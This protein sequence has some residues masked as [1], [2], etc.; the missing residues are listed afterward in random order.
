M[1]LRRLLPI[2]LSF[3]L[4]AASTIE[5][6][7]ESVGSS[8]VTE[9]ELLSRALVLTEA[10]NRPP[11]RGAA[12]ELAQG[13]LAIVG[14][15]AKPTAGTEGS[16]PA[17][18][19]GSPAPAAGRSIPVPVAV[20][21][22]DPIPNVV[23]EPDYTEAEG[24]HGF[25]ERLVAHL[26]NISG[27]SLLAEMRAFA[28]KAKETVKKGTTA[29][30]EI[31]S[32]A[33]AA[34]AAKNAWSENR[35]RVIAA[36]II[37]LLGIFM[38]FF[39]RKFFKLI[40]SILAFAAGAFVGLYIGGYAREIAPAYLSKY[41]EKLVKYAF[42]VVLGFA[43]MAICLY[44]FS[45]AIY[46]AASLLGYAIGVFILGLPFMAKV[47]V[48][49]SHRKIFLTVLSIIGGLCAHWFE[50]AVLLLVTSFL[51]ALVTVSAVDMVLDQGFVGNL[52]RQ[53]VDVRTAIKAGID[54]E[55]V[56]AQV[57]SLVS[58]FYSAQGT[59][60]YTMYAAAVVLT[61]LGFFYQAKS[62]VK[63]GDEEA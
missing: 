23:A 18:K 38:C 45:M 24:L 47:I 33:A 32:G 46:I 57:A 36:G 61:A 54:A 15:V 62:A 14:T 28:D 51:G 2:V 42:M 10:E 34:T 13:A 27:G 60:I 29:P 52:K 19:T 22:D 37:G 44:L 50:V 35:V 31:K 11:P 7:T 53:I 21:I 49:D 17:A 3:T 58:Q 16:G 56:K 30:P 41:S 26:P 8:D 4:I 55:V 43:L 6:S 9:E 63:R 39:G 48:Q 25:L 20:R 1:L 12:K 40:I 5:N 59:A